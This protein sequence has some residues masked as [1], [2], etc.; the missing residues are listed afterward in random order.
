MAKG[1]SMNAA[2][3]PDDRC[4]V[5]GCREPAYITYSAGPRRN[6]AVCLKHWAWSAFGG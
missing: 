5:K 4:R 6:A 2:I 1:Q 3:P